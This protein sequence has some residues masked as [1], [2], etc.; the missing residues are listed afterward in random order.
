LTT[1]NLWGPELPHQDIDRAQ[2]LEGVHTGRTSVPGIGR[3]RPAVGEHVGGIDGDDAE[4]IRRRR[5]GVIK[6]G[7][8][9]VEVLG[10]RPDG[11]RQQ[12]DRQRKTQGSGAEVSFHPPM[13]SRTNSPFI[14]RP[15]TGGV[16]LRD[17]H[18]Y[19]RGCQPASDPKAGRRPAQ[20][21]ARRTILKT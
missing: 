17:E 2:R 7:V 12:G 16:P 1:Q 6:L 20:N 18:P 15:A 10:R 19:P 3:V 14:I 8:I 5:L 11:G 9:G 13:V 21:G 4:P